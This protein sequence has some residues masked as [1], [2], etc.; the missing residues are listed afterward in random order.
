MPACELV[1]RPDVEDGRGP[2][3][4]AVEQLVA[5]HRLEL[6]T[7][8]EIARHYARD[9]GAVALAEPAQSG[10]QTHH[11]FVASEAIVDALAGTA[12]LY[13][14]SAAEK[15]QMSGCVGESEA[16][17]GRQILDAALALPEMFEQFKP[18]RMGERMGDQSKT[19][20]NLLFWPGA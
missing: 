18:M 10:E 2:A 20:K 9:F 15:L 13:K 1:L 6:V 11:H 12:P 7:S 17:A 8:P 5:R 16:R 3:A 14:C 4:Q 19:R